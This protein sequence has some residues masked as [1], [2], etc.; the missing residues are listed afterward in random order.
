MSAA[1][2]APDPPT[3][4][5]RSARLLGLVRRLID[6]GKEL[7]ATIRERVFT[8]P[9]SVRCGFG[10]ADV[11]LILAR[12][13]RGLHRANALEAR[14]LSKAHRL[15]A[16]PRRAA[17]PSS[18]RPPRPA[19]APLTA[20]RTPH[21]PPAHPRSDR[22]RG[23]PPADRRRHRRHLSRPRHHAPPPTVAR[24][25]ARDHQR[26]RQPR[27]PGERHARPGLSNRQPPY[28]PDRRRRPGKSP[29]PPAPARPE[30]PRT[31]SSWP[32]IGAK[33][34]AIRRPRFPP[35]RPSTRG[36]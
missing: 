35:P 25:A 22:H 36:C 13:S 12:I 6:Y 33:H 16:P 21:R 3:Q 18:P 23:P 34:R 30:T 9:I 26:G 27:P 2:N 4:P 31:A 10:T 5:S 14:L 19:T 7:A 17:S 20:K 32:R 28:L 11:A 8:D 24:T 29:R 1:A 15:D